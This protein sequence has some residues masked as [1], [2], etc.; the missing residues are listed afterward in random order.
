MTYAVKIS[1]QA[2]ADLRDIYE[3]IAYVL[4]SKANAVR[5]LG[6]LEKVI[7]SLDH[8][9]HRYPIFPKEPWHSRGVRRASVDRYVIF[10]VPDDSTASVTILRVMYGGRDIETELEK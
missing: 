3:Y 9:P 7:L 8:M 4:Q 6:R 10:Y 1:D 2:E 5:Q